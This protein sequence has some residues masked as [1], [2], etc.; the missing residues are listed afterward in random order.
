MQTQN[1]KLDFG[2]N[3]MLVLTCIYKSWSNNYVEATCQDICTATNPKLT[4]IWWQF[5]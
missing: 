4:G 3:F 5:S 1:N 2:P